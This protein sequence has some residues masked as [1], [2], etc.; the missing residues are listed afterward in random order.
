MALAPGTRLGPYEILALIG[1]GGMGQVYRARDSRLSRDVATKILPADLAG[2]PERIRRLDREAE[3]L[4]AINHPN[5]AHIYGVEHVAG[6]TALVME[7]VDGDDLATLLQT[8]PL[9]IDRSLRIAT[10][11]GEGLDAAHERGIIH[12][13]LKPSNVRV[14]ADGLVKVLDFGLA[15]VFDSH[16]GDG[17]SEMTSPAITGLGMVL[18]TT[19]YM[20]PEQARGQ[21]VDKRTDIWAFGCVLYEMLAGKRA[22]AGRTTSDTIA[23]I[24]AGDPDWN[25]L[26]AQM[27]HNIRRLLERCFEKEPR[28]RLRDIGD[29]VLEIRDASRSAV[30]IAVPGATVRF[31]WNW[32]VVASIAVALFL[33]A[34]SLRDA[35]N[36]EPLG[37]M[38][39]W[40]VDL[41]RSLDLAPAGGAEFV[42]S[43]DGRRMAFVS[44]NRLFTR[45]LDQAVAQ[46]LA[47]TE[48]AFGPFFSPDATWLGFFTQ[49]KLKKV[50]IET[51]EVVTLCDAPAGRGGTWGAN[52]LI[53]AA[54]TPTAGLSRI[55]AAGSTPEPITTLKKGEVTHRWPQLLPGE[56]SLIFTAN[57]RPFDFDNASI[58]L[59]TLAD[60]KTRVLQEHG[61]YGGFVG[62]A[63]Q[64]HLTFLRYGTLYAVP[65]DPVRGRIE[66]AA[67]P[68]IE[69]IVHH[70]AMGVA[71]VT[72]SNEGTLVYKPDPGLD[73][74][75]IEPSGSSTITIARTGDD[76]APAVSNDGERIAF[77]HRGDV[78][79][80]NLAANTRQRLSSSGDTVSPVWTPDGRYIIYG[81]RAGMDWVRSD[82]ASKAQSLTRTSDIQ[83]PTSVSPNGRWVITMQV[84]PGRGTQFDLMVIPIEGTVDGL[85]AGPAQDYLKT[86]YDERAA[87]FSPDGRW[88]AYASNKT[89]EF[90]I[91]LRTFPDTQREWPVS[92]DGGLWPHWTPKGD[93]LIFHTN[94]F[95]LMVA[96][97]RFAGDNVLP[98]PPRVWSERRL[99][100]TPEPFTIAP[101][102]RVLGVVSERGRAAADS[103]VTLVMNAFAQLPRI[104]PAAGK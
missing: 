70:S 42:L 57:T 37:A 100:R 41:G 40:N 73:V 56:R 33:A 78:W 5:V 75:W 23:A 13:D 72:L 102:G 44:D 29:A 59:L 38:A 85:R 20:S 80:L 14:R 92:T 104:V 86:E 26:P 90:Q 12:R 50:S 22:F 43:R 61:T 64:G 6:V 45:R 68:V 62:A 31:P 9:P 16:G 27:P 91:L 48:G 19:S 87:A 67:A 30:A 77:V 46:E 76:A 54:L 98:Q 36:V 15:K 103:Q 101:D 58:Q 63:Q 81:T 17:G 94:D 25:G 49:D 7:L 4:A 47:G 21:V 18:G 71:Q 55:A 99:A 89:G 69:G 53:I 74:Q 83:V 28:N 66:G 52:D 35:K 97:L 34:W 1:A 88:I 96:P 79:V 65:F 82:G 24:I 8:G 95:R 39:R 2:D 32:L 3:L 84:V 11:I 60:G 10:Q 51:G 93:Q